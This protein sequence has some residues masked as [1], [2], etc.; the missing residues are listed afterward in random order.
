MP[1]EWTGSGPELLLRV[2]RHQPEP[3]RDQLERAVREAIR[4]G[5]LAPG[6]RLPSSR[7]LARDLGISR[8]LVTE[9]YTQLQAEGYIVTR[10][11]SA[12]RVASTEHPSTT[13]P[14]R[15]SSAAPVTIDFRPGVPDLS[16][17]PREHWSRA[18]R[19]AC[20]DAPSDLLGYIDPHGSPALREV[21]AAYLRRVRGA[22]AEATHVL[23]CAGYAQGLQLVLRALAGEGMSVVAFEDPSDPDHRAIAAM[24]GLEVVGVP[25]DECGIDTGALAATNARAV[26]LT[27]AHQSPTG[28][29]LA[30]DRRQALIT[31]AAAHNATIIEDDYDA[32][33]RYD[34]EPVGVL[35][36]LAP[37]RVALLGSVSKSLAPALRLGWIVSPPHLT[38]AVAYQKKLS[39]RG[40]P[41]FDQLALADLVQSGRYDRHLRHMRTRYAARRAALVEALHRHAPKVELRGPSAGFHTV[42]QLP[43]GTDE[44]SVVAAARRRSVGLYGMSTYRVDQQTRPT[45]LVL[46]FGN[47]TVDAIADG[48]GSIADL[49]QGS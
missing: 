7:A 11:G 42:A 37:D 32:E 41:V 25:V 3:L 15:P 4:S 20:R 10:P 1:I 36:G 14:S 35:Q 26:V 23:I 49:L 8:G 31:W 39:D 12:T 5:R 34:R 33:F 22:A 48:I 2:D 21:I 46:G 6:E 29:V 16:S 30:P 27:P 45:Q 18:L 19:H 24:L 13:A 44:L 43:T 17:F 9:C 28:V 38:S 40:S 47:L